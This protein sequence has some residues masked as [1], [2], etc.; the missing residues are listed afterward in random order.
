MW[1][2]IILLE[3]GLVEMRMSRL[4]PAKWEFCSV[5]QHD[6]SA[7][8]SEGFPIAR[9]LP[10]PSCRNVHKII[11]PSSLNPCLASFSTNHNFWYQTQFRIWTSQTVLILLRNCSSIQYSAFNFNFVFYIHFKI[12]NNVLWRILWYGESLRGF[13]YVT[14]FSDCSSTVALSRLLIRLWAM[15][16]F[17]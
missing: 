1:A 3:W 8:P 2:Q 10:F 9:I 4:N 7:K 16:C 13:L 11:I 5:A 17:S 6:F 15:V 12:L 14:L